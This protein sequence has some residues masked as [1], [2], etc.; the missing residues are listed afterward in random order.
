MAVLGLAQTPLFQTLDAPVPQALGRVEA[1]ADF[2]GDG[3]MDLL[4]PGGIAVNDSHGRF[5]LVAVTALAF[6]RG[7]TIA[8]DLNGDGL[9][10]VVSTAPIGTVGAPIRIDR[11]LGG[12]AFQGPA[13]GAPTVP[14]P[15]WAANFAM[16]D[17]DGDGD[18][19]ILI[20]TKSNFGPIFAGP[21]FLW[22]NDATGSFT[23]VPPGILPTTPLSAD[24]HL[25][26]RDLDGD[27]D[28]D[29]LIAGSDIRVLTNTGTSMVVSQTIVANPFTA[30]LGN[31]NGDAF[32]DLVYS[33]YDSSN[34]GAM[35]VQLGSAS[36]F[37]SPVT[38]TFFAI[39]I[40]IQAVDLNADGIDEIV[41][42]G[43]I[44]YAGASVRPVT[45][46]G[47]GPPIQAFIDLTLIWGPGPRVVR[48]L[49]GDLDRDVLAAAGN[50]D[51]VTLMN[52]AAG[53]LV[54]IGGRLSGGHGMNLLQV[55]DVDAD[56]DRDLIG[57]G[58]LLLST[59][60]ND[61]DGN[62]TGGPTSPFG[63]LAR[64]AMDAVRVRPR[65]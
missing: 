10:E 40:T 32:P 18:L 41:E 50:G 5:T 26:L 30:E 62:F 34:W 15:H 1:I 64:V 49:D 42:Q 59:A 55:G 13:L 47:V 20:A 28:L 2:D 31:F 7:I 17:V 29:A 45:P 25:A 8:A 43:G 63:I 27:G 39:S 61:G 6:A 11:N 23:V 14:S 21:A 65:R 33:A 3:D 44:L 19:D 57:F 12:L 51:V 38:T 52:D 4:G 58:G 36:G 24:A 37:L 35:T 56:G 53:S 9:P 22:L 48:D 60:L 54:R 16:G 46:F